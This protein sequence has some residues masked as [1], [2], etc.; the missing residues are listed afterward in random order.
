[1]V[2]LMYLG[3]SA[4]KMSIYSPE[5]IQKPCGLVYSAQIDLVN[6]PDSII[7]NSISIILIFIQSEATTP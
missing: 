5:G 3:D 1:M 4:T 6:C 7:S 2:L